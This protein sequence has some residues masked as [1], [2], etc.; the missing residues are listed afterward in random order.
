[1]LHNIS[2]FEFINRIDDTLSDE[3]HED[4][5]NNGDGNTLLANATSVQAI[6]S[7]ADIRNVLSTIS[8]HN[9]LPQTTNIPST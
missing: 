5:L 6:I 3:H 4:V 7:P 9:S 1:M 8:N 2:A